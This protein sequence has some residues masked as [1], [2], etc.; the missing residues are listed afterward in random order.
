MKKLLL[1]F[2]AVTILGCSSDND[3]QNNSTASGEISLSGDKYP[4]ESGF[5]E[6]REYLYTIYLTKGSLSKNA[7]GKLKYSSDFQHAVRIYINYDYDH[8][9]DDLIGG[10][11]INNG[12]EV[13]LNGIEFMSNYEIVNGDADYFNKLLTNDD[14]DYSNGNVI[15]KKIGDEY[16]FSFVLITHIGLVTGHYRGKLT[17]LNY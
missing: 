6:K 7:D 5:I 3:S 15:I 9:P 14:L 8:L 4:L 10:L 11:Y 2:T 12:A 17:K 16:D 1:L 13:R